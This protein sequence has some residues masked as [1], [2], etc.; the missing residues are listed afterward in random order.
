M[1]WGEGVTKWMCNQCPYSG[2][3]PCYYDDGLSGGVCRPDGCPH[4]V[5]LAIWIIN[6]GTD[7]VKH[8]D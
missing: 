5:R 3:G 7:E 4:M 8:G 1:G 6:E 2:V